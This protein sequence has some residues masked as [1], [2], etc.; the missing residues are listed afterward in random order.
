MAEALASVEAGPDAQDW[1]VEPMTPSASA[2]PAGWRTWSFGT[3]GRL[4]YC[5]TGASP[6]AIV[7]SPGAAA[8]QA[9]G[10]ADPTAPLLAAVRD[11]LLAV[12]P[13]KDAVALAVTKWRVRLPQTWKIATSPTADGLIDGDGNAL[14]IVPAASSCDALIADDTKDTMRFDPA[15]L[16]AGWRATFSLREMTVILCAQVEG[17]AV[18][19]A[20]NPTSLPRRREL[21]A[22]LESLRRDNLAPAPI[23]V[24]STAPASP[25]PAGPTSSAPASSVTAVAEPTRRGGRPL[26]PFPIRLAYQTVGVADERGHGVRLGLD[27]RY[28]DEALSASLHGELGYDSLTKLGHDVQLR[29]ALR[30]LDAI[31]ALAAAGHD[32]WGTGEDAPAVPHGLYGGLGVGL[33]SVIGRSLV[34]LDGLYLWRSSEP[35]AGVT[36][37]D[38]ETRFRLAIFRRL[39]PIQ[40]LTGELRTTGDAS[41]LLIGAHLRL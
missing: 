3:K 25:S 36:E 7:I 5:A 40:G 8:I 35:V 4:A 24:A 28:G 34:R 18:H 1:E 9:T 11:E 31:S 26:L 39:G 33:A 10:A 20:T 21:V 14:A 12:P 22:V 29:V 23:A 27:R 15:W 19:A 41:T 32:G 2:A 13:A 30:V 38:T 37:P 16:P 6:T 17:G